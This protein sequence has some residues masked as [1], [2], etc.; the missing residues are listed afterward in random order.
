MQSK[1]LEK[2]SNTAPTILFCRV[3]F[4]TLLLNKLE[5]V[6]CCVVFCNLPRKFVEIH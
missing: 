2:S 3:A 6:D 1:A 4:S 5:Y